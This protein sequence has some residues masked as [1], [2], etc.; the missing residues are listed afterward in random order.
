[1]KKIVLLTGNELRHNYLIKYIA[2][3]PGINVLAAFSESSSGN[4]V[5]LVKKEGKNSLRAEHLNA[6]S[7]TEKDFFQ[8]YCEEQKN[9]INIID[10]HRGD[11]N[12]S[13]HVE[14]IVKLN[15]D[16]IVSYGCSIIKSDLL[17]VFKGRFVNIHLG[18]S[19]YYRGSGTNFWP[20][21]ENKLSLIGTTFMHIDEG[22]D[23][24]DIIHQ[25]RAKVEYGDSIH[26]IGNRLIIDS[27]SMC[28]KIINNYSRLKKHP[29]PILDS[30]KLFKNKDFT[31]EAIK[32]AYD[33]L[34]IKIKNYIE[35]K[36]LLDQK[37]PI[38]NA[39]E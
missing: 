29:H 8:L 5:E 33:S 39:F 30:G 23:T 20:F 2:S 16:L 1:M 31:E 18:L 7:E 37:F 22:I 35:N 36:S 14:Y 21:V 25:I 24:G 32:L 6:R 13:D 3:Q 4:I 28:V 17:N 11:I 38:I 12:N 27:V 19:P 10:I 34:D 9:S 15:P 26:S